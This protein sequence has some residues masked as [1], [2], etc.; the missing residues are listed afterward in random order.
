[1]NH[2]NRP[3]PLGLALGLLWGA[4]LTQPLA[5]AHAQAV[6]P[7]PRLSAPP[8]TPPV[9][10]PL[11]PADTAARELLN[12][13]RIEIAFGSYGIEVLENTATAR[14]SNLFSGAAEGRVCRTFAIVRYATSMAPQIAAEHEAIVRGGS[15]GAV[16]TASGWRVVKTHLHF[17]TLTAGRRPAELMRIAEGR[18]LAAHVYVLEVEKD[19][20]R[21]PY[22]T[23]AELH[24]P[25]YLVVGD[26]ERLYGRA[27]ASGRESLVAETL[28]LAA[29]KSHAVLPSPAPTPAPTATP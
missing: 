13:E 9:A 1:M 28:G 12:S 6:Q 16:F 8:Q 2:R 24:H 4:A 22:A 26:L 5:P 29:Q 11:P 10:Q 19:G 25:D 3:W 17:G 15:I 7:Q 20:R 27:D 18:A 21:F 23:L 14:V